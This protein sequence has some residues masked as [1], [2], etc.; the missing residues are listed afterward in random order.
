MNMLSIVLGL[1]A[2]ASTTAYIFSFI[3]IKKMSNDLLMIKDLSSDGIDIHTKN[4]IKFLSDSREMAFDYI[5]NAQDQIKNFLDIADKEFAFFDAYGSLT[6]E[7]PHYDAMKIISEEYK[8]LKSL[9]PE[10]QS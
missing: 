1:I 8:K 3:K 4:F 10:E 6:S 7:Y 5:D 2:I 9:L